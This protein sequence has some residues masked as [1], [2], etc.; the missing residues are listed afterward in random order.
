MAERGTIG[1]IARLDNEVQK[2]LRRG[3]IRMAH[4]VPGDDEATVHQFDLVSVDETSITY[5]PL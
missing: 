3:I 1:V 4:L 5:K 2:A